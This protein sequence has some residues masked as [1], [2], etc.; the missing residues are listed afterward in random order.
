MLSHTDKSLQPR[1]LN[2]LL[3]FHLPTETRP[4][5]ERHWILERAQIMCHLLASCILDSAGEWSSSWCKLEQ[6]HWHLY[7]K[8]P[9]TSPYEYIKK[10]TIAR[11]QYV[12]DTSPTPAMPQACPGTRR[13]GEGLMTSSGTWRCSSTVYCIQITTFSLSSTA[14]RT[15]KALILLLVQHLAE[16]MFS[17]SLG[18]NGTKKLCYKE[19]M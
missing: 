16:T 4:P 3:S 8:V 14:V 2:L 17:L 13:L 7:L 19:L 12:L 5:Q 1:L 9:T 6:P 10:L 15:T 11:V 18:S